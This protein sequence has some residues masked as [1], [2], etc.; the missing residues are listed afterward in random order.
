MGVSSI[1][2][3]IYNTQSHAMKSRITCHKKQKAAV[4]ITSHQLIT[5]IC[6]V[7]THSVA[8]LP[9]PSSIFCSSSHDKYYPR[10]ALPIF[11][12]Y[13]P[14]LE[15]H[16]FYYTCTPVRDILVGKGERTRF[17]FVPPASFPLAGTGQREGGE[18][19]RI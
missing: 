6:I 17:S 10:N 15:F 9:L 18:K 14:I 13:I 12:R 7:I 19:G 8:L 2:T 16:D 3:F 1:N 5:C 4:N 11:H